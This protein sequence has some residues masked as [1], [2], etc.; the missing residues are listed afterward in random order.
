MHKE[1]VGMRSLLLIMHIF[2][3]RDV[4]NGEL[5]E[6]VLSLIGQNELSTSNGP[7][8]SMF[9]RLWIYELYNYKRRHSNTSTFIFESIVISFGL[10]DSSCTNT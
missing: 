6:N 4:A 10:A 5:M 2:P 7:N 8:G 3:L 9:Q 1:D